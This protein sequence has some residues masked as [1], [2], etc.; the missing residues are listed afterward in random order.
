VSNLNASVVYV[1]NHP[2]E[3][4]AQIPVGGSF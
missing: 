2:I 1:R 3:N 4:I